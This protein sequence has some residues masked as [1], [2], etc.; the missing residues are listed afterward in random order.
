MNGSLSI[1]DD[2]RRAGDLRGVDRRQADAAGAEDGDR[3]AGLDPRRVDD[4]AVAGDDAAADQAGEVERHV[5]A[6]L[7]ERV[8]VDD[9]L[10]GERRQVE[11]LVEVLALPGQ[12]LGDAGRSIFTSGVW[13]I[14][15]WPLRQNSQWPQ[16]TD[17]QEMTWS[18]GLT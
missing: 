6:H 7:H 10:L 18:P 15:R 5:V 16:N 2:A 1:G 3:R 4:R 17:R 9:H 14:E 12:P 8:L 13:Q 11:E